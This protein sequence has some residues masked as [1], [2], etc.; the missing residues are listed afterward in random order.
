LSTPAFNCFSTSLQRRHC[1]PEAALRPH[2]LEEYQALIL[3]MAKGNPTWG[4]VPPPHG[5]LT[6]VKIYAGAEASFQKVS[7]TLSIDAA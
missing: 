3:Q 7:A 5:E 2:G 6:D 4:C 1:P